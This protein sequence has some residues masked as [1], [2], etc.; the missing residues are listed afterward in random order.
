MSFGISHAALIISLLALLFTLFSFWWMNWRRGNIRVGIPRSYAAK[1]SK[2]NTLLVEIPIVFFNDGATPILIQNLRL[3]FPEESPKGEPLTFVAT[4]EKIGTDEGR[5]F[6]SQF[7]VHKREALKLIC[8]F[9]RTPGDLIFEVKQYLVELQA[10]L[11]DKTDW[12]TLCLFPIN[13]TNHSLK[14]INERFITHDNWSDYSAW[15]GG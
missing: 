9:H 11:D 13:V 8:E 10:V 12:V 7:P 14:T 4:V 6:A 15:P 5:T 3:I 1:G 2:N